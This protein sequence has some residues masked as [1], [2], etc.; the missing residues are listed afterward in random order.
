MFV[1]YSLMI[2]YI[3]YIW[4]NH[5]N[6]VFRKSTSIMGYSQMQEYPH[7]FP[8][9]QG[10]FLEETLP[11]WKVTRVKTTKSEWKPKLERR[12]LHD[13]LI[14]GLD[15]IWT[16]FM[17]SDSHCP[18]LK[19]CIYYGVPKCIGLFPSIITN[20]HESPNK[21]DVNENMH[22]CCLVTKIYINIKL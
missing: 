5:F 20:A 18:N 12:S 22:I 2:I 10:V 14:F 17:I 4:K 1:Q 7:A 8:K 19:Q 11:Q 16:H 21:L 9:Q 15:D 13:C 3:F 6:D